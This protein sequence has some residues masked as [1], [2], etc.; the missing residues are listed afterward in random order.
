[1]A[2]AVPKDLPMLE[3]LLTKNG[4]RPDNMFCL[5][6]TTESIASCHTEPALRGPLTDHVPILTVLGL[7]VQCTSIKHTQNFKEI[8]WKEFKKMLKNKLIKYPFPQPIITEVESQ[9]TAEGLTRAIVETIE[10]VI[11]M[12]HPSPHVKHWWNRDI[13]NCPPEHYKEAP[14]VH[15]SRSTDAPPIKTQSTARNPFQGKARK[16]NN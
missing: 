13:P 7:E 1:M 14:H 16:I 2:M 10:E 5:D 12:S 6:N 11:P 4:T 8:D 3:A 9:V 15:S